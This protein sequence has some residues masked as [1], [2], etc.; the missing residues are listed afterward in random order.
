MIKSISD[1][2]N[3]KIVVME[4]MNNSNK[5]INGYAMLR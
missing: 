5:I 4:A 3:E 1:L 2:M